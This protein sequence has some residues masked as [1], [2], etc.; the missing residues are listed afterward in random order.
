MRRDLLSNIQEWKIRER[1][2][3]VKGLRMEW[4]KY[5]SSVQVFGIQTKLLHLNSVEQKQRQCK[6]CFLSGVLLGI[7][8]NQ[9]V[10]S[11]FSSVQFSRSVVSDSLQPHELQHARPACPSP[12]PGVYSNSCPSSRWCHPTISSSV[13]PFSSCPQFLPASESFSNESTLRMRWPK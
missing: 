1:T 9:N 4:A 10:R 13:V 12:T 8:V 5:G 6:H 3:S 7:A 2:A 11:L